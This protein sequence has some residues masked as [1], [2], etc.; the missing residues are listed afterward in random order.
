[1]M[2]L[3]TLKLLQG[4]QPRLFATSRTIRRRPFNIEAAVYAAVT[5]TYAE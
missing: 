5:A 4:F 2:P 1:M 3:P